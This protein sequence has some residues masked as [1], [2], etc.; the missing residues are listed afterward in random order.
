MPCLSAVSRLSPLLR[1]VPPSIMHQVAAAY[2]AFVEWS[3]AFIIA[4]DGAA[5]ARLP[6]L[7]ELAHDPIVC[8]NQT[9]LGHE[10]HDRP[11]FPPQAHLPIEKAVSDLPAATPSKEQPRSVVTPWS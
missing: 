7:E 8:Q 10:A 2:D 3:L 6:T 4:D 5:A 1:T 9:D 11:T